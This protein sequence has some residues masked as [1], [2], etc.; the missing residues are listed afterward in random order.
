M[1]P[2]RTLSFFAAFAV[3]A[4]SFAAKPPAADFTAS[5]PGLH[6]TTTL[7]SFKIKRGSEDL[8]KGTLDIHFSGTVLISG[9]KGVADPI[10]GVKLEYDRPD[11]SR[12]VFHGR[13][14]LHI[15][16]EFG[17][18]LFFGQDL[19]ALYTGSGV[20]Q[21]FGEFD[22]NLETGYYWYDGDSAKKTDWG[23]TGVTILP[24][25]YAPANSPTKIKIKN[26]TG[27]G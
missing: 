20:I 12:K 15:S 6:L 1:T 4:A 19:S 9:L 27:Q 11:M 13:G 7:G 5:S 21:L 8:N 26:V 10:G 2:I 17:S 16:G 22:K 3:S 23:T 24:H 25:P 14:A 18:I